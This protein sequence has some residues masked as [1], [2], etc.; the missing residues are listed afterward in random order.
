MKQ[1]IYDDPA[2][3]D[4]YQRLRDTDSGLNGAV[5]DPAVRSLLPDLRG[6]HILDL[7]CGFGDFCRFARAHGAAR[8]V[9]V[10]LSQRMLAAAKS[11]T[12]DERIEY[13]HAAIED[14]AIP[15][16]AF[17]LIVSRMALHYVADYHSVVQSVHR[18]LRPDGN[19]VC[20]VEHP[21][22]TSLCQGW[23]ESND[24]EKRHWPVDNY[25]LETER[26]HHWVVDGVV[27]HHRT[28]ATY[29]NTMLEAGFTLTRLLEPHVVSE[30]REK[31]PDLAV[32]FRRPPILV[33]AAIKTFRESDL[34]I[35]QP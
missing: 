22:C 16:A 14:F 20:S 2:F 27:K 21:I 18:G 29:V 26:K 19:F 35:F 23:C 5:E 11:R 13:V 34:P 15:A 3:F 10:E 30:H 7:G 25:S 24:G 4:G 1:N 17:D 9:G 6:L 31:R 33:L 28:I 8:A 12:S 32:T